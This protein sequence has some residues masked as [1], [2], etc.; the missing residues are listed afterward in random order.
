M[1][2]EIPVRTPSLPLPAQQRG[3]L[4]RG[5]QCLG[6]RLFSPYPG[7]A[8]SILRYKLALGVAAL[9]TAAIIIILL[10]PLATV[11]ASPLS[12]TITPVSDATVGSYYPNTNFGHDDTISVKYKSSRQTSRC[13]IRINLAAA[14]SSSAIIDSAWLNLLQEGGEGDGNLAVYLV[15]QD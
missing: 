14:L 9:L 12:V 13:L 4:G 3:A 8:G 11:R 5:W 6:L 1:K 10:L 15:T 7:K 2:W